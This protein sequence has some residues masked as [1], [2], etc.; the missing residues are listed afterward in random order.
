MNKIK[1]LL[2]AIF[3]VLVSTTNAQE[4]IAVANKKERKDVKDITFID[5]INIY[6]KVAEQDLAKGIENPKLF[7]RLASSYYYNAAYD[8]AAKWY[9]HYYNLKGT[10]P[11]L[12][13]NYRFGQVLKVKGHLEKADNLLQTYY[14][15]KGL[16]YRTS[17]I[18][19]TPEINNEYRYTPKVFRHN[20]EYAE[21]PA[22]VFGTTLYLAT[23][24]TPGKKYRKGRVS[25]SNLASLDVAD[26]KIKNLSSGVNTTY[27][28]GS[29]VFTK[30][31][32]TMYFSRN[33]F[34]KDRV[35]KTKEDVVTINI[36]KATL[37]AGEWKKITS[38]PFNSQDY[39][40]GHPALSKDEKTFYFIS[41]IPGGK[42]GTDLYSVPI[43][44]DGTFGAIK[45][46]DAINTI[47]KEMFPF[48]DADDV[49]YFSSDRAESIGGL[50]VFMAPLGTN[51]TYNRVFSPGNQINSSY[52]DFGYVVG[53]NRNVYIGSNRNLGADDIFSFLE[54]RKFIFPT[55]KAL[56]GIAKDYEN[57]TGI[58]NLKVSIFRDRREKHVLYHRRKRRV[59]NFRKEY[60]SRYR[61][62]K[63]GC[64]R[65]KNG[66]NERHFR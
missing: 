11:T 43:S 16:R 27:N 56:E 26:G 28:E 5:A 29:M 18:V 2:F 20:S 38:L 51:K 15:Y 40:T 63:Q 65:Y 24:N 8:K 32:K 30:D 55:M 48:V 52:D 42:G 17:N 12:L 34:I 21:Y 58:P 50:D 22:T 37:E 57:N 61:N 47:G 10:T 49:L 59:S 25:T 44:E 64:F 60:S 9:G 1:Y 53:K 54:K 46:M 6:A 62:W 4:S 45:N 19:E 7:L 66:E 35:R 23:N 39:S 36:Y 13:D 41:D 31:G 3:V 33:D 14:E